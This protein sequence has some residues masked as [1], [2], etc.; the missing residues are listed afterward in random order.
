M[1]DP[2]HEFWTKIQK[3]DAIIANGINR[4]YRFHQPKCLARLYLKDN[5]TLMTLLCTALDDE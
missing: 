1:R 5:N 4:E 2:T 3:T